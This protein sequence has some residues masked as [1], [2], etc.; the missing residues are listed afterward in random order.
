MIV[1]SL[2]CLYGCYRRDYFL[3]HTSFLLVLVLLCWG[4][5]QLSCL[6][7]HIS[8]EEPFGSSADGREHKLAHFQKRKLILPAATVPFIQPGLADRKP[9]DFQGAIPGKL[10]SKISFKRNMMKG[11]YIISLSFVLLFSPLLFF[12]FKEK[13]RV[14]P[15]LI[16]KESRTYIDSVSCLSD[17]SSLRFVSS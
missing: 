5:K 16:Q 6:E 10:Q 15:I 17:C 13:T 2:F 11:N 7:I 12:C 14:K 8:S 1:I 4:F 3:F 9:R